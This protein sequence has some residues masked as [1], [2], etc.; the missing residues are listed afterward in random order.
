MKLVKYIC[1]L[2][3][4]CLV[5]CDKT[6]YLEDKYYE[7]SSFVE[8]DKEGLNELIDNKE[9][10]A[11]FVYQPLCEASVEFENVLTK[12]LEKYKI[13]IYKVSFS[14][15]KDEDLGKT[16]KYYPSFAIYKDGK[17]VDYLESDK[18]EDIQKYKS[19]DNFKNWFTSSVKLKDLNEEKLEEDIVDNK[20]EDVLLENIT[21]DEN[22]VN[23]YFFWGD[24][25]PHCAKAHEFFDSIENEYG[26]YYTLNTFEV[27]HSEIN[28]NIMHN[29]ASKMNE[30]VSV[31][32]YI[33]I[34]N[35]TFKGFTDSYKEDILEAIRNQYKNSYDVYFDKE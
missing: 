31:I 32:P 16:I 29:F 2:F 34:G 3:V 19:L 13:I 10:F 22:K 21:Y 17:I 23:I 20:K 12:F 14:D 26:N 33:I 8:L 18:D 4:V 30:E 9:S 15:I 27:W 1:L 7:K 25:C 28:Q 11:V 35:K 24:G 5:G 6:F